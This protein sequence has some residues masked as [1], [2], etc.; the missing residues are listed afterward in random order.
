[1]AVPTTLADLSPTLASNSP[2]GTDVIGTNLDDYI[3]AAYGFI[4]QLHG[5]TQTQL[6]T[7]FTTGGTATAFTL[8]PTPASAG[9]A[10]NQRFRVKFNA[11]AGATPTLAVS[12]QTAKALKYYDST[13]AKQAVT[14]TQIPENWI[15][16][17]EYDGTDWV[18]IN[19]PPSGRAYVLVRDEK[20]ANTAGGTFTSG[21][22]RTRDINTEVIDTAG[23]CSISSNQI[24][25]E[26][27]TY[28]ADISAPAS[29]CDRHNARLQN[30]TDA[31]TVLDGTSEFSAGVNYGSTRSLITGRFTISAQKTFEIQHQCQTTKATDG[32]G[33]A[34]NFGVAEVYT[35]AKFVRV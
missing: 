19:V 2:A 13:G 33:V 34:S 24:T 4:S 17:V 31:T 7:A 28:E 10:T 23:I 1:M 3:R 27:G 16:D 5:A 26:A 18:V 8:T 29:S 32:F 21:A 15:S 30:V 20:T 6:Y 9:N 22:W 11:A 35:V 25:L 14:S 12:G